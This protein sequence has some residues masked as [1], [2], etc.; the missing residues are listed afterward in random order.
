M[1]NVLITG[2]C[3]FIGFNIT[4]NLMRSY[5][6]QIIDNFNAFY[7]PLIKKKNWEMLKKIHTQNKYASTLDVINKDILNLQDS[8]FL[9]TD[10][11]YIIHL[12]AEPGV[13]ESFKNKEIYFKQNIEGTE[14]I[15]QFASTLNIEKFI[16]FS[17]SSV[18]GN[19]ENYPL[20]EDMIPH[21]VS[22]YG[23]SKYEAEKVCSKYSKK[24]TFPIFTLRPFSVYGPQ[25]RPGLAIS[26]FM[27][28]IL[29]GQKINVLGNGEKMRDFT[30]IFD[31]IQAVNLCLD[32]NLDNGHYI[33]NV[34]NGNSISIKDL[35]SK[36]S[37]I[38][39]KKPSI[40]FKDEFFG[41]VDKTWASLDKIESELNYKPKI[42]I[43]KG[44]KLYT[45]WIQ[46]PDDLNQLIL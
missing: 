45:E 41:D 40:C 34:G 15:L 20:S 33:F 38:V 13:R 25:L 44:L 28:R 17:S 2:G 5:N 14:S 29:N 16:N 30:H 19:Q 31:V 26:N 7:N 23:E 37:S 42:D 18:Y 8:S 1:R 27:K 39:K 35:I 10:F 11:N 12:A 32:A 22:P 21:P 4:A 6:I 46:N 36:I 3:G 24:V 43:D 9:K